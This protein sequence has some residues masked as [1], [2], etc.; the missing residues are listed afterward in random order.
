[1][2][3][4]CR[5]FVP[6]AGLDAGNLVARA[7]SPAGQVGAGAAGLAGPAALTVPLGPGTMPMRLGVAGTLPGGFRAVETEVGGVHPAA[8]LTDRFGVLEAE[9]SESRKLD[10]QVECISRPGCYPAAF[11]FFLHEHRF[12]M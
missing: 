2:T 4:A 5:C 1:M 8:A 11:L 10:H 7:I 3:L 6:A 9:L 12:V